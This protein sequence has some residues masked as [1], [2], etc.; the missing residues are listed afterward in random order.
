M[1]FTA[2]GQNVIS[3]EQRDRGAESRV[4]GHRASDDACLHPA[5]LAFPVGLGRRRE[6]VRGNRLS[7]AIGPSPALCSATQ[8]SGS[9]G[10]RSPT[11]QP[12]PPDTDR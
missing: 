2:R 1:L 5:L 6:P 12:A 3:D 9:A 7:G 10:D 8:P 11:L 4:G